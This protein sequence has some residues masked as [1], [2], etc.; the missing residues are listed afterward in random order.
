[1]IYTFN[2]YLFLNKSQKTFYSYLSKY[3]TPYNFNYFYNF[4]SLAGLFLAI[5]ILSGFFLTMFYTPHVDYAF[6]SVEHIMRNVNY[7]WLIRYMHSN[8]ASFFF[9][10]SL[11][12]YYQRIILWFIQ[13][14]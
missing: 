4:G 8:G 5:Q 12:T 13:T 10:N 11:F 2:N 14:T 3:P 1:M 9:S 6:D 7:G